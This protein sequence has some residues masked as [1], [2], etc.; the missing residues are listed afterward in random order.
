MTH[1]MALRE[2]SLIV[3]R[4]LLDGPSR[5][6][7]MESV[8]E[9]A[10]EQMSSGDRIAV[11][12]SHARYFAALARKARSR[13]SKEDAAEW[14]NRLEDDRENLRAT[15]D[16]AFNE[17]DLELA[18]EMAIDLDWFWFTRGYRE[19]RW[20]RVEQVRA[21]LDALDGI[22]PAALLWSA[23]FEENEQAREIYN[24][25]IR[26]FEEKNDT[27]GVAGAIYGL[28]TLAAGEHNY[29]E[30]ITLLTKCVAT[31][32]AC[33]DY[34]GM[35][36]SMAA[37]ASVY[38]ERGD[39]ADAQAMLNEQLKGQIEQGN[40]DGSAKVR[41]AL[42]SMSLEQGDYGSARSLLDLSLSTYRNL[43][44][45]WGVADSRRNIGKVLFAQGSHAESEACLKESVELFSEI[46]D[47]RMVGC[48]L[49]DL[50]EQAWERLENQRAAALLDECMQYVET[51]IGSGD[52]IRLRWLQSAVAASEG[53]ADRAKA[54]FDDAMKYIDGSGVGD[55]AAWL[56]YHA[57][58]LY[59]LCGDTYG[60]A[61]AL[62]EGIS[63]AASAGLKPCLLRMLVVASELIAFLGRR[64]DALFLS[65]AIN[66]LSDRLSIPCS[67]REQEYRKRIRLQHSETAIPG[68]VTEEEVFATEIGLPELTDLALKTISSL[69]KL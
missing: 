9:Y 14:M 40:I 27:E 16:W 26:L 21:S 52:F 30:A 34:E 36:A 56:Q 13:Y 10:A 3:S 39:F 25:C 50:A 5:F 7:M 37:L 53:R 4:E 44:Q 2:C 54:L 42:A 47:R 67:P 46:A 29:P 68:H 17:G 33:G 1:L 64:Q 11:A 45:R 28:G 15:M 69:H 32:K 57:A 8:R 58:R 35:D 24:T 61:C 12:A 48:L 59:L 66:S 63:R 41:I 65:D 22:R 20:S 49:L 23:R 60:A 19:E 51:D 55:C 43:G 6:S 62:N 38:R 31:Y 18:V